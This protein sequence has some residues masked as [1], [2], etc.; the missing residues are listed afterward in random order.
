VSRELS[1][2]SGPN[3]LAGRIFSPAEASAK[4]IGILFIHGSGSHQGGYHRR[5][6][7]A[8]DRLGATC[9][10]F[11]LS[12]HGK[13]TGSRATLSIRDHLHDC[14]A[15]FDTLLRGR[16]VTATRIGVCGASYGAYLAALLLSQRSLASVLL[17]APG[18]YSDREI[19]VPG[20]PEASSEKT[21]GTAAT[22]RNVSRY[23]GPILFVESEHDETIPHAVLEAYLAASRDGALKV[24]PNA[25]H[26]LSDE[27]VKALF[28]EF[29][30]E[31]FDKTLA[32]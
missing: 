14:I 30:V 10:T 32:R 4:G 6:A 7:A 28:I 22:L 8:A 2:R 1:F 20:G 25:G 18:L 29:I 21:V 9:L 11:D 16:G 15:A 3:S 17:R 26:R 24:M 12:G 31:W 27:R 23:D 13:S 19:D 5:A